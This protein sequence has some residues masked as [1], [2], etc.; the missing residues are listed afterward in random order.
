M[1]MDD[2][3]DTGSEEQ[4]TQV[5]QSFQNYQSVLVTGEEY[6]TY[7]L[8]HLESQEYLFPAGVSIVLHLKVHMV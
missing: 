8:R 4:L 5:D 6:S 3:W 1:W 7:I 2:A